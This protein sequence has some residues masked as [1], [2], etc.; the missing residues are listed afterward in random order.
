[1]DDLSTRTS[2]LRQVG[3]GQW[4]A[5]A[6]GALLSVAVA[7]A[8]LA[9]PLVV[10]ELITA[11]ATHD[12]LS[13]WLPLL[14][15]LAL[16][17][18]LGAGA[19]AVIVARVAENLVRRIRDALVWRTLR[20][21]VR[22]VGR[23]GAGDLTSRL[24]A[25]T[26][27]FRGAL[28]IGLGQLP[29]AAL[30]VVGTLAAMVYL[31]PVLLA[32]AAVAFVAAALVIRWL[33]RG[34]QATA[35]DHQ[36]H[37][38]ILAQGYAGALG[39]L[40]TVKALRA[41]PHL[42]DRL[43][44][45]TRRAAD[46]GVAYAWR[47]AFLSP[48]TALAQ[49]F[50]LVGVIVV[51][52]TRIESGALSFADLAAFLLYLLQ[53]V[54]PVSVVAMGLGRLKSG[55]AIRARFDELLDAPLE[56][57]PGAGT[58]PGRGAAAPG[59]E[60]DR[61]AFAYDGQPVLDGVSFTAPA[62]GMTAVVGPSGAGKTTALKLV[63]RFERPAA[64]QVRVAGLD[65]A[66]WDL[67]AL[68]GVLGYVDQDS[69]ML[70]DTIRA[71]LVVGAGREVSDEELVRHLDQVGLAGLVADLP[72][73]LDT[74][75]DAG[76]ELSGG[77]RQRLAITR[78]LVGGASV[79]LLDEPTSQ[80]DGLSEDRFRRLAEELAQRCC[81]VVVAH[82]LSTVRNASQIVVLENGRVAGVGSHRQLLDECDL[83]AHL[84]ASQSLAS[85]RP[86]ARTPTGE[87]VA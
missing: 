22:D 5:V 66:D 64:G 41:E 85:D 16:V 39:A 29:Q 62:I 57:E 6:A 70:G 34:L 27:Q 79:V 9:M 1:M 81:V 69:T 14:G 2:L 83:Y 82:R 32:V 49:Q 44:R 75:L 13:P 76:F 80:L 33:Y 38:G 7:A 50:A 4:P 60:F 46:S 18:A 78:A 53:V 48:V 61:V 10:S 42:G 47:Q 84:V 71:N 52:A 25:D 11:V 68:R 15:G 65:V 12:G 26:S 19:Q 17:C 24:T 87:F 56:A 77:Q 36:T 35:V 86:E 43:G 58:V 45:D 54:T 31:D 55:M 37:L 63:E 20:M 30:L 23:L 73:G 3:R 67:E 72:D 51:G 8:S 59:V 74:R 28:D 40:P 21:P